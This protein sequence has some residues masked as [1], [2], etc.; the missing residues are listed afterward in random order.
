MLPPRRATCCRYA[1]SAILHAQL[2]SRSVRLADVF[3]L[4]VRGGVLRCVGVL[5]LSAPPF[6]GRTCVRKVIVLITHSVTSN[7]DCLA[8]SS[9]S[10]PVR[11][12]VTIIPRGSVNT[13]N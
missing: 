9:F 1:I 11:Y 10:V 4:G 5:P 13:Q 6:N 12:D 2:R 3:V 7:A 8:I